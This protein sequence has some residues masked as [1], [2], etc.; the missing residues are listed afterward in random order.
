[1]RSR[2]LGFFLPL[3]LL[4]CS[5]SLQA[6]EKPEWELGWGY[7]HGIAPHY[8]GS[9]EYYY[10]DNPFP[11]FIFRQ[12]EF[13]IGE[14]GSRV[15]LY[16]GNGLEVDVTLGGRLPIWTQG[17]DAEAPEG[18]DDPDQRLDRGRS[19]HRRGM[20][21]TPAALLVGLRATYHLGE[22]LYF[23]API[24]QGVGFIRSLPNMG[25]TGL[26]GGGIDFFERKSSHSLIIDYYRSYGDRRFNQTYYGVSRKDV[27]PGRERYQAKSG[28]IHDSYGI[29]G[30]FYLGD[31]WILGLSWAVERMDKSALNA[32]PL[33]VT[34]RGYVQGL[35][36]VYKFLASEKKVR[37]RK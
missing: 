9:N 15:Y 35:A 30:S 7:L 33:V 27:L 10:F 34:E 32:S 28:F 11:Y 36:V 2:A 20:D 29:S 14:N 23:T 13:E 22:H 5:L 26:I 16:R 21:K 18:I 24:Y 25:I 1:M 37:I 4:L 12:E 31:H 3:F 6:A 8:T 17:R 19:W